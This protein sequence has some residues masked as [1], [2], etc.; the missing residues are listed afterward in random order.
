[1][2]VLFTN[3]TELNISVK[4]VCRKSS[5]NR[6]ISTVV[7]TMVSKPVDIQCPVNRQCHSRMPRFKT[8]KVKTKQ[9]RIAQVKVG[10]TVMAHATFWRKRMWKK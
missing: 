5:T 1:M 4:S 9:A 2:G 6:F 3:R 10:F 7:Y 8:Y